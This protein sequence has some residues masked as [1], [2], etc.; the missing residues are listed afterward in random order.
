MIKYN[1]EYQVYV[2][3]EGRIFNKEMKEYKLQTT[4]DGYLKLHTHRDGKC[5]DKSVHRIV[6][7]TFNEE[8]PEGLQVDHVNNVRNDNRLENLQLLTSQA[9]NYKRPSNKT[10]FGIKYLEHYGHSR[11]ENPKQYKREFIWYRRHNNTCR[12]E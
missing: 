2:S 5:I 4:K 8:I 11:K 6:Y 1:E 9:N 12:W 3:D 10:D 7:E